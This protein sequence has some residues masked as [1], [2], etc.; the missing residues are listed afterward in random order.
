MNRALYNLIYII[1]CLA[2]PAMFAGGGTRTGFAQTS[3][4]VAP[5]AVF[6]ADKLPTDTSYL[7]IGLF[8]RRDMTTL[9]VQAMVGNWKMRL[10]PRPVASGSEPILSAEI[11]EPIPEGEDITV[12][13]TG[14]GI[15]VNTSSGKELAEGY[16]RCDL[17][18]GNTLLVE[19]SNRPPIILAGTL[20]ISCHEK[21]LAFIHRVSHGTYLT[22]VVSDLTPSS[23]PDAIKAAV[24]AAR[25]R[26]VRMLLD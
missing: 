4:A 7:N 26:L 8:E 12:L 9:R 17:E 16:A 23:E 11:V 10:L 1:V 19:T 3:A 20:A 6:S 14:K 13:L 15:T 24:I 5:K 21:S 22:S 2:I 25:S 18:G